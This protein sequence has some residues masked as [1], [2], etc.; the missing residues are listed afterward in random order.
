MALTGVIGLKA[1]ILIAAAA[2]ILFLINQ[3]PRKVRR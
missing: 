3:Y 2:C 1:E